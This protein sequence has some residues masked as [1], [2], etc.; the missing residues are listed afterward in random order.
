MRAR[1]AHLIHPYAKKLRQLG[2]VHGD[3]DY[4]NSTKKNRKRFPWVR[5]QDLDLKRETPIGFSENNI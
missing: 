4:R 5:S 1:G 3:L 2:D